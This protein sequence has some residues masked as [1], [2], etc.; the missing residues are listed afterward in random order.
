LSQEEVIDLLQAAPFQNI[1][2]RPFCK[3]GEKAETKQ[4]RLEAKYAALQVVPNIEKLGTAKQAQ[5]ARDGDLLTRERLCCGLSIFEVILN[6]IK[7]FLDDAVWHGKAPTNGVINIDECTEFHRLWSA[8]QFVYCTPVGEN[9]FT[10]EH[11]F[12]EGLNWAGCVMILLLGQQRRFECL[13]FCYH[14][15]RVQ[16]VDR[17][18]ENIKGIQLKRMVDR[19]RRFQVLNSQIFAQLNKYLNTSLSENENMPVEHVRCFQPPIHQSLAQSHYGTRESAY[20]T[21]E[22]PTY[23]TRESTYGTRENPNAA[24]GTIGRDRG[25]GGNIR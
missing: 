25:G 5:I 21:R 19:I 15:F 4:K 13:D 17:R 7:G 6:R 22:N 18:D 12:G 3:E 8:L 2:P 10:V 16:K 20:G 1:L 24:Y 14:I 23:G 9:E 11:L